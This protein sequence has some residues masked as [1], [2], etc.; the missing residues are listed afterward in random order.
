[1]HSHVGIDVAKDTLVVHV[2]PYERAWSVPNTEEG[3]A[4]LLADLRPLQCQRIVFEASGGYEYALLQALHQAGLPAI[5]LSA[6]RP[7]Y[8]ARALGLTAKT[9]ALDARLLALAAQLL[10]HRP[11]PPLAADA[12]RLREWLQL[13]AALVQERDGHRR[14]AQQVQSAPVRDMLQQLIHTLQ[15][16]IAQVDAQLRQG[17]AQDPQPLPKVPGLGPILRATL[18]ARLPELGQLNRRQIAA[19]VGLAPFNRDSGRW[20]GR[21]CIGGGRADVRRVLYMATWAAIRARAPLAETYQRLVAA[22]KP[23][24]LALTAC[25]R[26][27]LSHLNA[28][29]R[30]NAS[31]QPHRTAANDS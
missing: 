24:K 2:L 5:R 16:Q 22:G 19:L 20:H 12:Q 3:R 11:T 8:L 1:M 18:K 4:A 15:G 29:A 10:P 7:R 30:D 14:R 23:K 27:Y 26:K 28:I 21:R 25:M 6:Q 17:L 13:R 31:W 9:D